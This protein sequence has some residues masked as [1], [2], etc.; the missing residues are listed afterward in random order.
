[1]AYYRVSFRPNSVD[2]IATRANFFCQEQE[3]G[4]LW[5][6]I[7]R[8]VVREGELHRPV[9]WERGRTT[10]NDRIKRVPA[11]VIACVGG[12][13]LVLHTAASAAIS[14]IAWGRACSGKTVELYRLS[15]RSGMEVRIATYG[16][17]ITSLKVPDKRGHLSN[18][19]LG[20]DDLAGY[21]NPQYV[22]ASPYFGAIIGRYA[23]RIARGTFSINEKTYHVP[24][25][26]PPNSLHG[27]LIG[28]DK[29][30]WDA[31]ENAG[32]APSLILHHLSKDG[33]QGY[34]GNLDVTVTYTL[35][36]KNELR[37]EY[38]AVTDKDTIINLTNHSYFNLKGAGEGDILGQ[39]LSLNAAG[40]TPVDATL[41]PTG[42]VDLV[43]ES[44]FDFRRPT[45]IG[46]R[47]GSADAQLRF[48]KGYDH[49]FVLAGASGA[50]RRA[51]RLYD[52]VTGRTLEIWTT[53]P[54]IQFYS[55][56]FLDGSLRSSAG[57]PFVHRGGVALETQHFPDSP[58]HAEFPSTELR[59]GKEFKS[60][61]TWRFSV[62]RPGAG[63]QTIHPSRVRR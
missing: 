41:I 11:A 35:T 2:P 8:A 32:R 60:E 24:I 43:A 29:V 15:N 54:G 56:N 46:L 25:N 58:N 37:M 26:N 45:P 19:V 17:I 23:N 51:A 30:V 38:R 55:G 39:E 36:R 53:E 18:V 48:G 4:R 16:G 14:H 40:Y 6:N 62:D 1:M 61:T 3:A 31:R 13:L 33:D 21:T 20:F 34:P 7:E 52:P 44:A 57:K 63:S 59:L 12:L 47:I 5:E 9:A 42:A 50:L 28:F 22:K 49:N 27:G 10:M